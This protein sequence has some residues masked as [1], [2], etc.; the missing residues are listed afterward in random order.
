[1]PLACPASPVDYT[2]HGVETLKVGSLGTFHTLD[3]ALKYGAKYL[4]SSTSECY[5]DPLEHP[6]D[7]PPISVHGIIRQ[8]R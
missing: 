2:V 8:V 1:M 5:G 3:F 6:H 7:L 4:V